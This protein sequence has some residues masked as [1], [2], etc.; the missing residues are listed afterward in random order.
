MSSDDEPDEEKVFIV[1]SMKEN[2]APCC[3]KE[4]EAEGG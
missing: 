2:D 3:V 1:K 4:D